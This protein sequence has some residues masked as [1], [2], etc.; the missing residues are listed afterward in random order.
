MLYVDMCLFLFL[1]GLA[2]SH[3]NS[4]NLLRGMSPFL[5]LDPRQICRSS[6]PTFKGQGLLRRFEQKVEAQAGGLP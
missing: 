4:M 6:N 2:R 1:W 3:G 5:L